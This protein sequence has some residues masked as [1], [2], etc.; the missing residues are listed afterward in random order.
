METLDGYVLRIAERGA[1]AEL[2]LRDEPFEVVLVDI[3]LPDQSGLTLGRTIA[4]TY[5]NTSVIALTALNDWRTAEQAMAAGFQGYLT[6]DTDLP[7]LVDAM[8]IT[9]EGHTVMPTRLARRANTETRSR[10]SAALLADSLTQRERD[11]LGLLVKGHGS[12]HISLVLGISTNTVRSHIQNILP[13]LQVHSR[14]E[15]AAFAVRHKLVP[16]P[17]SDDRPGD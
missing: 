3:G 17:S 11:V 2:I 4:E 12:E 8:R 14:L 7:K 10:N 13:K 5:P 1:D 15:A 9:R 16:D 6:K